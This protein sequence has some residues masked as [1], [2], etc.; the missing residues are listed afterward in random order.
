MDLD[1]FENNRLKEQRSGPGKRRNHHDAPLYI[2]PPSL[3]SLFFGEVR[4]LP[5]V[6][7]G[8]LEV[9]YPLAPRLS[10]RGLHKVNPLLL[11]FFVFSVRIFNEDRII[12]SVDRFL[13]RSNLFLRNQLGNAID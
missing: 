13:S 9:R 3:S 10:R 4:D 5:E 7:F 6:T 2:L 1:S 12:G 11:Q 8:V